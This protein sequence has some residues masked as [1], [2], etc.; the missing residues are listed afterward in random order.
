MFRFFVRVFEITSVCDTKCHVNEVLHTLSLYSLLRRGFKDF[1]VCS[2]A[3]ALNDKHFFS[4][5]GDAIR[6]REETKYRENESERSLCQISHDICTK[7]RICVP[8]VKIGQG[9]G[10]KSLT[11]HCKI[12]QQTVWAYCTKLSN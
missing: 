2:Y 5:A 7:G 8:S 11:F 4:N 3:N 9:D 1:L 12:Y 10:I 6:G